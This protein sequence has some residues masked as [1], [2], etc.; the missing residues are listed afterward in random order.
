MEEVVN[1]VMDFLRNG[2]GNM[3][4]STVN[5]ASGI[6]SSTV[7]FFIAL[8]FSVYLLTQKEKLQDQF[9]RLLRAITNVTTRTTD[10]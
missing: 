3:I 7:N 6:I 4:A 10:R 9:K 1:M 5:V 2:L 8:I